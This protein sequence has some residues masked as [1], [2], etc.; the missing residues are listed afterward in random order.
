[1]EQAPE[2]SHTGLISRVILGLILRDDSESHQV[3]SVTAKM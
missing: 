2:E 1:M 3:S